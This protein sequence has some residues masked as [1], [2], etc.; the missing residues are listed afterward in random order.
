[1]SNILLE[2][3][4]KPELFTYA[5]KIRCHTDISGE[6]D[7]NPIINW[8]ESRGFYI[9]IYCHGHEVSY[10]SKRPHWHL[11][12]VVFR[13]EAWHH[14]THIQQLFKQTYKG[15]PY[16]K[17]ALSLKLEPL[18]DRD[19]LLMY[20]LKDQESVTQ[21]NFNGSDVDSDT[22]PYIQTLHTQATTLA[23]EKLKYLKDKENK[24][25]GKKKTYIDLVNFINENIEKDPRWEALIQTDPDEE[26][27]EYLGKI[28]NLNLALFI[29]GVYIVDF[30]RI[31]YDS[32]IPWNIDRVGLRFLSSH[33][34]ILSKD[35]YRLLSH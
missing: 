18:E 27:S 34:L 7:F 13:H 16:G 24:E 5:I 32:Q 20:P 4:E 2:V 10:K 33:N 30:Y 19:K 22:L 15:P 23:R 25:E 14:K 3:K 1:M 31:K 8:L 21:C 11:H 35:I 9:S 17:H 29:V 6:T 28:K 26:N 12:A